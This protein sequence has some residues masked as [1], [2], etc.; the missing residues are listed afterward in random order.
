MNENTNVKLL[1]FLGLAKKAG[2]LV[3]GCELVCDTVRSGKKVY[4][5]II[6]S[7]V[8]QNT[9]KRLVN[10][11]NNYGIEYRIANVLQSELSHAVGRQSNV[12][13]VAVLDENF[14][15]AIIKLV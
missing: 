1:G 6:S 12:S 10:C 7:D 8:A 13:S 3:C 15:N 14:G 11:C 9:R 2:K 4:L 5:V